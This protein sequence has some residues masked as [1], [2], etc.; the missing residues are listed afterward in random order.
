MLTCKTNAQNVCVVCGRENPFPGALRMCPGG[1]GL[2]DRVARGLSAIGVTKAR[3]NKLF[4]TS[5]CGCPKRQ[6]RLNDLGRK[7][8]I[9]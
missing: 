5:D 7:F 8:G 2:G 1:N 3:V 6:Q 9:G 4:G